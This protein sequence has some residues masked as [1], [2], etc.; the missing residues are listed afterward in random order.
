MK[1]IKNTESEIGSALR[2]RTT[3]GDENLAPDFLR[4][5]E[6][7]EYLLSLATVHVYA[8][9]CVFVAPFL[10]ASMSAVV[11]CLYFMCDLRKLQ[12]RLKGMRSYCGLLDRNPAAERIRIAAHIHRHRMYKKIH[13]RR[14][15]RKQAT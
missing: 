14:R 9:V 12:E 6:A 2:G 7:L 3:R 15:D 1:E 10:C 8:L 5:H 11:V 4:L 13:R